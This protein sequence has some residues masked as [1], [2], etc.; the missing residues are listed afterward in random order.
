MLLEKISTLIVKHPS[1]IISTMLLVS[2]LSCLGFLTMRPPNL[3]EEFFVSDDSRV[4]KDLKTAGKYFPSIR[5]RREEVILS[6][7]AKSGNNV[8][9]SAC[10]KDALLVHKTVVTLN[11][12]QDICMVARNERH[13]QNISCMMTNPLEVCD[14][15]E[16]NHEHCL[17]AIV[18][19]WKNTS[20]TLSDGRTFK[21]N[22]QL[23]MNGFKPDN[24]SAEK[25]NTS[26][27]AIRLIYYLKNPAEGDPSRQKILSWE[28]SFLEEMEELRSKMTCASL[29]FT[30]SLTRESVAALLFSV[31]SSAIVLTFAVLFCTCVFLVTCTLASFRPLT[32]FLGFL[33]SVCVA[34]GLVSS[35]SISCM[36]SVNIW[37]SNWILVILM[38]C[39]G[40]MDALIL[41]KDMHKQRHMPSV[42]HRI[43]NCMTK[44]GMALTTSNLISIVVFGFALMSSFPVFREFTLVALINVLYH[45]L[46]FLILFMACLFVCLKKYKYEEI[47]CH[48]V[49]D[50]VV[51]TGPSRE[52]KQEDESTCCPLVRIYG[53]IICNK[54]GSVVT[55]ILFVSVVACSAY[56][57]L[58]SNQ[59]FDSPLKTSPMTEAAKFTNEERKLFEN[60]NLVKI[61]FSG[62]LNYSNQELQ[63]KLYNFGKT[64]SSAPYSQRPV[65]SWISRLEEWAKLQS[66]TCTGPLFE[67]CLVNFLKDPKNSFIREDMNFTL[68]N[69][70]LNL[71]ASYFHL[72]MISSDEFHLKKR[73]LKSLQSDTTDFKEETQH[74]QVSIASHFLEETEQLITVKKECIWF[75]I[76]AGIATT[77]LS[78]ILTANPRLTVVL[79]VGFVVQVLELIALLNLWD[80]PL[81][82]ASVISLALGFI[83]SVNF[84]VQ[85]SQIRA[86]SVDTTARK[87]TLDALNSV[88][89]AI[90]SGGILAIL[91]SIGLGFIFPNLSL[92]FLWVLPFH[93]ALGVF[94]SIAFIPSALLLTSKP[95]EA[96]AQA[97]APSFQ[98][99]EQQFELREHQRANQKISCKDSLQKS[100][101][102][103]VAILGVSCRFPNAPNKELFWDML[104]KGKCGFQQDYPANRPS[105]HSNYHMLYNPKRFTPGR[106]C[107]LG[108]AYLD[109]IRDFDAEF[110]NISPQEA[111]AMDPQQRILLQIAYEAIEDAGLRLEDLQKGNTGVFVGAMN[112]DYSSR[113]M[114]PENRNNLDQFYSTG[115]TASI[116]ANRISFCLNL[117]GPSLTVDT[118]CS[119]SLVALRI[120]SECLHSGE[121]DVAI[122]CAPNIILDPSVQIIFSVGGLLAPDGRCK[123]F[124][125]SG[126]GYGR[127]EGFAAVILKLT[128]DAVMDRDDIYCDI[129]AC[130]MNNDGQSA[131]PITAPSA[132]TQA[133][134]SQRVL[135]E[136]GLDAEDIEYL[137][138]HGTG[139]AIGDVVEMKSVAKTYCSNASGN[140]R[141]LRVGSVKSNLNHTESAS[142]LAGL[143]KVALMLKNNTLVPT[144]SVNTLNPKLK[145]SEKGIKVQD[146]CEPWPKQDGSPRIAAINSFGYGGTNV[147]AILQE[148][149]EVNSIAHRESSR[150]NHVLTLS[151]HSENALHDMAKQHAKWLK[152]NAE[153]ENAKSDICWSLNTRRSQHPHR[154]AVVFESLQGAANLLEQ[155]GERK[156][157]WEDHVSQGRAMREHTKAVFVFGGQGANWNGMGRQLIHCEPLFRDTISEVSR[158]IQ[159]LGEMW[160]LENELLYQ[161]NNS[162]LLGN[163]VGQPATFALQYA[164]AKLLESWGIVPA[165]V[166]GHSLGEITASCVTGALTLEEAI[167]IILLRSRCHEL[168]SSDGC[169]AALGMSEEDAT[170]LII[171]LRLENSI[172]IAAIND[173]KNVTISGDKLSIECVQNHLKLNN[174]Q[175][176][177]KKLSTARA[178]HSFQVEMVKD[179]FQSQIKSLHLHPQ[180]TTIPMYSTVTGDVVSGTTMD[181]NYWWRNFR[182][183]VQFC[184]AVQN[185]Q[186]DNHTL[187]IEISAQPSLGHYIKRISQQESH[188][189]Q[190][191][192]VV[193]VPTHP[194]KSV[195]DQH[196]AFLHNTVSKLY[197]MGYSVDW[198]RVQGEESV[199][200]RFIRT[201]TY[202]WQKKDYWYVQDE[203]TKLEERFQL[204]RHAF[205]TNVKPTS[206]FTGLQCWEVEVDLYQYPTLRDHALTH[207]GPVLPGSACIEMA[208][209]MTVEKFCCDEVEV[210]NI[211]FANIL[212]IPENQVRLLR[213]QLQDGKEVDTAEFQV[214]TIPG[215][216]SEILLARGE[217]TAVLGE[218]RMRRNPEQGIKTVKFALIL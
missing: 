151:A 93:F 17:E 18:R 24:K 164:T 70:T 150:K 2:A 7:M 69:D 94:H 166:I 79:A 16:K 44:S 211:Q 33:M 147:H 30:S 209:A 4:T 145:L 161:E 153:Y 199:D 91:S 179:L 10:L 1:K 196:I 167:R 31:N 100:R 87:R 29:Y 152:D 61:V 187:L 12:Y 66:F 163:L 42:E 178:F 208:I 124:D 73:Y 125:V 41:I 186:R 195:D 185:V 107:A 53:K 59:T 116:L 81:N 86:L 98:Q 25:G 127:G 206:S 205:L 194:R 213:L 204:H 35:V 171:Q 45:Y 99:P 58:K 202:P 177:W 52:N 189:S 14:L 77:V 43:A 169:M 200:A 38:Y 172:S 181:E 142:G 143:I 68:Q 212:T 85:M 149:Q 110:F 67:K 96:C 192:N 146:V 3:Q 106:L 21:F 27:R 75:A 170:Q 131:V 88:G 105:E 203:P 40:A 134:L 71:V 48:P 159:G 193:Y 117:T 118:A 173:E 82:Y 28:A 109:N 22:Q 156:T 198:D 104:S 115:V 60:E 34:I 157:G 90:L 140:G 119:S 162:N 89:T 55:L 138:A 19:E 165:A 144:V 183:P 129:I 160:S 174:M 201:P 6:P 76:I 13:L 65:D 197:T 32:L 130:G 9:S 137:E 207:G 92:I 218:G 121:C 123:S 184:K 132:K 39:K 74:I 148:Y 139:T 36:A 180:A 216:G 23:F 83:I 57:A 26:A 103:G 113:V 8:L 47:S 158:V 120:A 15:K 191:T 168:C 114:Q 5:S 51:E 50:S 78:L 97:I 37:Q 54:L 80:I 64:L 84:S 154:L 49:A 155:F 176:F 63:Q 20:S 112:L 136:S 135:E 141:V 175:V 215:D 111:K 190:S 128:N 95:M 182:Q 11:N 133:E 210:K 217:V 102:S 122:V 214:K 108:G 126:D 46:F 56:L 72:Y 62:K 188:P 101:P